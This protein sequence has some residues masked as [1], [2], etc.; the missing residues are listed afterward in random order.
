MED[1]RSRSVLG[2]DRFI[3]IAFLHIW[4]ILQDIPAA[5]VSTTRPFKGCSF[6]GC[7]LT[8]SQKPNVHGLLQIL[9]QAA[10]PHHHKQAGK[11][12]D[13]RSSPE[14]LWQRS[15]RRLS[16]RSDGWVTGSSGPLQ[17]HGRQRFPVRMTQELTETM[18]KVEGHDTPTSRSDIVR[19]PR[20]HQPIREELS[21]TLD[22]SVR[23]GRVVYVE[24]PYF[25]NSYGLQ[26]R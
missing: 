25:A 14:P 23:P 2:R 4:R 9:H 17:H 8:K 18:N 15:S 3:L 5:T 20:K 11:D 1:G 22:P 10:Q 7:L 6:K 13:R 19:D 16:Q 12:T 21:I 26:T 24:I